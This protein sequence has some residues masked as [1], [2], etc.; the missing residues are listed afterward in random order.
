MDR[1]QLFRFA[2]AVA[3]ALG[4]LAA[5]MQA[6]EV[7]VI[8]TKVDDGDVML[9]QDAVNENDNRT[10]LREGSISLT[11]V[12]PGRAVKIVVDRATSFQTMYGDGAAMTDSSAWVLMKL[13]QRNPQLYD[14][15]MKK[16]FSPT[17]GAGFSLL[18]LPI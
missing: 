6:G 1:N 4:L 7:R 16:L 10:L 5:S 15:T 2:C 14:Y 9:V 12:E 3:G 17:E 11:A 18:R 13:K 8:L